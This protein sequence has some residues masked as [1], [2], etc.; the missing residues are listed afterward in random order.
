MLFKDNQ[1]NNKLKYSSIICKI[2]K[3]LQIWYTLSKHKLLNQS[4]NLI[5]FSEN[6]KPPTEIYLIKISLG[7]NN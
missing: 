5:K 4:K 2:N 6:L 1:I 3:N 7:Y